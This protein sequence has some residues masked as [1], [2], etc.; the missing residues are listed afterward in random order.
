M[1]GL[2][3][4]DSF[5]EN[6]IQIDKLKDFYD[7]NN[8]IKI[9][10]HVNFE[11]GKAVGLGLG[12]GHPVTIHVYDNSKDRLIFV[13]TEKISPEGSF[14]FIIPPAEFKEKKKYSIAIFYGPPKENFRNT[15]FSGSAELFV[16]ISASEYKKQIEEKQR[17]IEE[18]QRIELATLQKSTQKNYSDSND[19]LWVL[20]LFS[21][22]MGFV[23]MVGI[24]KRSRGSSNHRQSPR[25]Y[26]YGYPPD[27]D[28]D[29]DDDEDEWDEDD[30]EDDEDEWDEDVAEFERFKKRI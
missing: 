21:I 19:N 13:N 7:N 11:N 12:A 3:I 30:D 9:L 29:E 5:A 20:L 28:D 6:T 2:M 10:G 1:I 18:Q 24:K 27:E 14:S 16:G 4:P 15:S 26:G 23:I 22:I 25:G 8:S 17:Q